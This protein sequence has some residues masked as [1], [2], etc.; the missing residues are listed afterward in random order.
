MI[1]KAEPK[2]AQTIA[3]FQQY[4]ARETESVELNMNL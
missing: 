2:D 3:D 1:R 4:M